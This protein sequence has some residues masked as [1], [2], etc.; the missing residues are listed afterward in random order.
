MKPDDYIQSFFDTIKKQLL[1][2]TRGADGKSTRYRNSVVVATW[3]ND[4]WDVELRGGESE[5]I[6]RL[7]DP[8]NARSSE[9]A[10]NYFV[11]A[12]LRAAGQEPLPREIDPSRFRYSRR[13][14]SP[15]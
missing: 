4:L 2:A 3:S 1:S 5:P 7:Y 10:A 11:D 8:L 6:R 13:V 14:K 12:L 9:A 15:S